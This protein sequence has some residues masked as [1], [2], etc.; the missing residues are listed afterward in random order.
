MELTSH[1]KVIT[2]MFTNDNPNLYV[3]L[4]RWW[5]GYK[6]EI[7]WKGPILPLLEDFMPGFQRLKHIYWSIRHRTT[8]VYHKIDTG[9]PPEYYDI[10]TLM[11]HGMFSLLCRYVES[12]QGGEAKMLGFI[13]ELESNWGNNFEDVPEEHREDAK[14][15]NQRQANTMKDA[16]RLWHWW[17]D[18]YPKYTDYD[19]NPWHHYC[20]KKHPNISNIFDNL[21]P[22]TTDKDGDPTSFTSNNNNTPEERIESRVALDASLKYEDE[23]EEDITKAMIDLIKLRKSLWT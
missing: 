11:V 7:R 5:K 14:Y 4:R 1:G 10:D 15:I 21:V 8:D 18:V 19:N 17:K 23:C 12:E 3:R 22:Y 13:K 16:L 2:N 6:S 9:L 20:D